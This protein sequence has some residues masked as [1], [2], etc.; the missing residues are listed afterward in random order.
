MREGGYGV[1]L[2]EEENIGRF[3]IVQDTASAIINLRNIYIGSKMLP[4]N[5]SL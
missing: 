2:K 3:E 1:Q 5:N 4:Y